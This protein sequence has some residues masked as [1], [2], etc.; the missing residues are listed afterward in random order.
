LTEDQLTSGTLKGAGLKSFTKRWPCNKVYYKISNSAKE[1]DIIAAMQHYE[2]YTNLRFIE[3]TDQNNYIDFV[4][5]SDNC[6]KLGMTGGRQEIRLSSGAWKGT[7]IHEIGHAIGLI[8]EHCKEGRDAAII[9]VWDNIEGGVHIKKNF[10]ETK[11]RYFIDRFHFYS[12][13]L[14]HSFEQ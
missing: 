1:N 5:A 14:Y 7:A 11:T 4:S 9:I 12:V 8:H 10:Y 6:S 13:M 2:T 3:R